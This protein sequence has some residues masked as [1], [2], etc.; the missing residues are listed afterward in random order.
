MVA[1]MAAVKVELDVVGLPAPPLP[2][3]ARG[4]A[5]APAEMNA[6]EVKS[7]ESE[8][9]VQQVKVEIKTVEV[10]SER[11]PPGER[12]AQ[13]ARAVRAELR[14]GGLPTHGG[15]EEL[16]ARLAEHSHE[17]KIHRVDPKFAS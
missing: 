13:Q 4:R 1:G 17:G 16:T 2:G 14:A 10:K 6:V 3:D 12:L 9:Q 11:K 15:A 5:R 7:E 8:L